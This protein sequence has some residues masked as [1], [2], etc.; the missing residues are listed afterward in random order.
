M[1]E[2]DTDV[3]A[4]LTCE[5]VRNPHSLTYLQTKKQKMGHAL[6]LDGTERTS[7]PRA[8]GALNHPGVFRADAGHPQ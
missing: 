1:M 7:S 3:I 2:K 5:A 6:M 8:N 4:Q